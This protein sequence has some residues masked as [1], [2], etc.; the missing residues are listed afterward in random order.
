[1][2]IV[3]V[4]VSGGIDSLYALVSLQE[5]GH[6]VLA[7]HAHLHDHAPAHLHDHAPA[8][9]HA[10]VPGTATMPPETYNETPNI[11][12]LAQVCAT[13]NVPLHCVDIRTLF[14][15]HVIQAFVA[16]YATGQ[17]PNPCARCN[18]H[19]KFG[20]L[21]DA[22][23]Q[24]GATH[25]A[26]GHYAKLARHPKYGQVL[27]S[28]ADTSKDQSYFLALTPSAQ[29]ENV[30]FPLATITK[31]EAR[32]TIAERGLA[33][34]IPT[35]S[36]DICFIPKEGYQ[37][38]LQSQGLPAQQGAICL[39]NGQAIGTHTGLWNYTEG[40][41]KGLGIG[42]QEP[43][44][45]LRKDM[46]TNRLIVGTQAELLQDVVSANAVLC[47]VAQKDWP[48]ELF[49]RVRYRQAAQK[50]TVSLEDGKLTAHFQ[51]PQSQSAAGQ[52]MVVYDAEKYI[53][54]AGIIL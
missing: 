30:L 10:H 46:L 20:A 36:Q 6:T 8:H 52:V 41:R 40:Q 23:L 51:S 48:S 29:L 17:T 24:H 26:T 15:K 1:M 4:A 21:R 43:L 7:I 9:L 14:K 39:E 25:F 47:H 54:A 34:P 18:A 42:W 16:S 19:I 44:Y 3:A 38:F 11:Q 50:A 45:V 27:Q 2:H 35:E 49:V 12:A 37:T 53:L 5:Q 13:L 28:A 33:V 22:A 31:A 32:R